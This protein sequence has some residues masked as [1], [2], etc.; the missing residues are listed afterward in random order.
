NPQTR[1][2]QH[3]RR[4]QVR[5]LKSAPGTSPDAP[6]K[7]QRSLRDRRTLISTLL[8][9]ATGIVTVLACIPLFS[10]LIMLLWRGGAA[11]SWQLFVELPPTAFE[12]G[13]GF[14]NA[15]VGTLVM[16][17]IAAGLSVPFGILAAVF[18]AEFGPD[19]H[20]ASVVRFCAKT[21]TGFPSI[22]AGV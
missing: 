2:Y 18:L 3:L 6:P 14:G 1:H 7:L 10:T 13:G 11:L 20:V 22:L 8:S 16:V 4:A 19:S 21:L 15:I 17:G 12:E 5:P 9:L